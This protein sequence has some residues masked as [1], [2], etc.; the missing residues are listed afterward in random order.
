M[1]FI[2]INLPL[3]IITIQPSLLV[4]SAKGDEGDNDDEIDGGGEAEDPLES[5][6]NTPRNVTPYEDRPLLPGDQKFVH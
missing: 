6:N 3:H 1:I 5:K 4:F 2:A